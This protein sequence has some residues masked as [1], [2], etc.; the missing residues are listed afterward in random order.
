MGKTAS[1]SS[2]EERVGCCVGCATCG[3]RGS[4]HTTPLFPPLALDACARLLTLLPPGPAPI[5]QTW[6]TPRY[7]WGCLRARARVRALFSC[8]FFPGSPATLTAPRPR[9]ARGPESRAHASRAMAPRLGHAARFVRC[10]SVGDP[11][12]ERGREGEW[13]GL[14]CARVPFAHSAQVYYSHPRKYGP[15]SR[16]CRVCGN[17]HG[18]IRKY[19]LN[20]CRQCFREVANDVGFKKYR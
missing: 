19:D 13:V 6:D 3:T 16:Q 12:A 11:P 2:V 1:R 15:G 18:M 17:G 7:V 4:R 20:I 10:F 9:R 14:C 5:F 8:A